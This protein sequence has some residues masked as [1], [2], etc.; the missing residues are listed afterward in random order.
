MPLSTSQQIT[1]YYEEFGNVDVTFTKEVIR[2]TMLYPKQ[3]YLKCLGF[4]WPCVIYSSSMNGAKIIVH[5]KPALKEAIQKSNNL[6]SLRFSF[7]QRDKIDPLSFFVSAKIAGATPYNEKNPE[8]SIMTLTYTQRPADDLIE[9]LGLLLEATTNSK[10][11]KE[12]RIT[13]TAA[14]MRQM[15]IRAKGTTV[16]IGGVPRKCIVRDVSFSGAK[17][18]IPGVAPFLVNKDAVLR[19][20]LEE[21]DDVL[22]IRG[23]V[24]RFEAVEGRKDI[25]AFAI[26]FDEDSVP[27]KY[28]MRINN[29]LKQ[30]KT[31]RDSHN[32]NT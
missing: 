26:S 4:Q 3:V 20:V 25:A 12:E 15:G 2:A 9:I 8:L 24:I 10:K 17:V 32:V 16:Y 27:M 18:I 31:A 6:V 13:L 14:S 5:V 19:I 21:P 29:F 7:L 22:D 28:K 30:S 23:K 1:R 11:R